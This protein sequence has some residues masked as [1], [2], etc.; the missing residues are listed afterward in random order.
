MWR[1]K[2]I[3]KILAELAGC[4]GRW[5]LHFFSPACHTGNQFSRN[6]SKCE[7]AEKLLFAVRLKILAELAGCL[8]NWPL[9]FFS[10]A[11]HTGNQ[12]SRN[13]WLG[14]HWMIVHWPWSLDRGD[15]VLPLGSSW[16][17]NLQF[18]YTH[19]YNPRFV[20]FSLTFWSSFMYCDLWSYVWLVF[21]GRF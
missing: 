12:C 21:K 2:T 14:V 8:G 15:W 20:Y 5:P 17:E 11:C 4:L 1:V 13:Y 7:T 18:T 10:T 9:H 6:C 19:H 16:T 3:T